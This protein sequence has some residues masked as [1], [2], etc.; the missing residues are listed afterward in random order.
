MLHQLD[1]V[2]HYY[3]DLHSK[4]VND[5]RQTLITRFV[6]APATAAPPP[7]PELTPSAEDDN[8]VNFLGFEC[9]VRG[10]KLDDRSRRCQ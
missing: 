2:M 7:Q 3:A 6:R 9:F 1:K 10:R 8:E 4:K 5:R